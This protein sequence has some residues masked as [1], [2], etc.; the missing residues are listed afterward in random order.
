MSCNLSLSGN[1]STLSIH[2]NLIS[3]TLSLYENLMSINLPLYGMP[4][5][6]TLSLSGMPMYSVLLFYGMSMSS[7]LLLSGMS[8]SST[9]SFYFS[10]KRTNTLLVRK[11]HL[12][13][14]NQKTQRREMAF[15][16]WLKPKLFNW[17]TVHYL[18]VHN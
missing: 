3:W 9:P 12:L 10:M 13:F 1:T 11:K 17:R 14:F 5:S 15:V 8:M 2:G 16:H 7:T 18:L 6:S 4:M